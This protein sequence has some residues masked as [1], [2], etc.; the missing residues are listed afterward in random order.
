ML[1]RC[2]KSRYRFSGQI[3]TFFEIKIVFKDF[4]FEIE[5][6]EKVGAYRIADGLQE[7]LVKMANTDHRAI[8]K[9]ILKKYEGDHI[10]DVHFSASQQKFIISAEAGTP[11]TMKRDIK[12]M[13][14][15]YAVSF[16]YSAKN[17]DELMGGEEFDPLKPHLD[18]LRSPVDED[19]VD[20]GVFD[21][22]EP[23]EDELRETEEFPAEDISDDPYSMDQLMLERARDYIKRIAL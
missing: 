4:L 8:T 18:A 3:K 17:I 16:R 22:M 1:R 19:Y 5:C 15:P 13:A 20:L 14:D 21:D 12:N 23:T 2:C 6:A 7:R 10:K 11:N 9:K